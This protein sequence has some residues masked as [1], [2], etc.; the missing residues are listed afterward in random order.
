MEAWL[1]YFF[2]FCW[3]YWVVCSI[4]TKIYLT[5]FEKVW[6]IFKNDDFSLKEIIAHFTFTYC[7]SPRLNHLAPNFPYKNVPSARILLA[8]CN[9]F[10]TI[11][12]NIINIWT[13]R[14]SFLQTQ[15]K[16]PKKNV[17]SLWSWRS[18]K[19]IKNL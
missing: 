14:A 18:W 2:G 5:T 16:R 8:F 12:R 4:Y 19:A 17:Y 11:L 6:I 13:K 1:K 3:V 9:N 15:W 7:I 10:A